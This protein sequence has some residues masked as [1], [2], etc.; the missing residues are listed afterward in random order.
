M[1]EFSP[2]FWAEIPFGE[3][4]LMGRITPCGHRELDMCSISTSKNFPTLPRA[5][6]RSHS[7]GVAGLFCPPRS[8]LAFVFAG[9]NGASLSP[10]LEER[11]TSAW[12]IG[13]ARDFEQDPRF[14]LIVFRRLRLAPFPAV[15]DPGTAIDILG[16]GVGILSRWTDH[17]PV[18]VLYPRL[19]VAALQ[20][21]DFFDDLFRPIARDG[22]KLVEVQIRLQKALWAL[23]PR[24]GSE[25]VPDCGAAPF[26]GGAAAG[27]EI[28]FPRMGSRRTCSCRWR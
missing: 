17:E 22:A 10:E 9:K 5:G 16:R 14:G 15:N 27:G 19:S 4:F 24:S 3:I 23:G 7:G 2:L 1:R 26:S 6:S 13:E 25:N 11:I 21:D 8:S 18:D 28:P 12:S 20:L